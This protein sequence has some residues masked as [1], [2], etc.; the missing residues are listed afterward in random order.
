MSEISLKKVQNVSFSVIFQALE[1]EIGI[2][3]K[4]GGLYLSYSR[5]LLDDEK[6]KWYEIPFKEI[7][8]IELE[9]E[10]KDV[11]LN[12]RFGGSGGLRVK[13]ENKETLLALRHFL[14]P[15]IGGTGGLNE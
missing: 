6:G 3:W 1:P 8:S 2:F 5:L 7:S 4:D 13:G 10:G 12:F 14:L 15:L 11:V 9:E